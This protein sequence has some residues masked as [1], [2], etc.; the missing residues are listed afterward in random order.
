M[1]SS[2]KRLLGFRLDP[3]NPYRI[4]P[5]E[6]SEEVYFALGR[7]IWRHQKKMQ[8]LG[9]CGLPGLKWLWKCDGD[10]EF[11]DFK[12]NGR[13]ASLDRERTDDSGDTYRE[14]DLLPSDEPTPEAI[15][16]DRIMLD[17]LL[18]R[19]AELCPDALAAGSMMVD[20]DI[21]QRKALEMLQ[22]NRTTYRSQF[23]KACSQVCQ[24]FGVDSIDELF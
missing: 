22:M 19:L 5:Q 13:C 1:E 20:Q 11:C 2:K 16:V 6:V 15:T 24:E 8:A 18:G 23:E 4:T 12:R 21:S 3:N 14:G 7:P 17:K 9:K 10:C